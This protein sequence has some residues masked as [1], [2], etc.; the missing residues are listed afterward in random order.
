MT[1]PSFILFTSLLPPSKPLCTPSRPDLQAS[2]PTSDP[3][4][5]LNK[6]SN[7]CMLPPPPPPSEGSS[8]GSGMAGALV[9]FH[10]ALLRSKT[11]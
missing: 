4:G 7:L 11:A 5:P 2:S 8:A 3:L 10:A 9:C 6:S 1:S